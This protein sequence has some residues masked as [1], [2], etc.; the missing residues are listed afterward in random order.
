MRQYGIQALIIRP[1]WRVL[2]DLFSGFLSFWLV[3]GAGILIDHI[4]T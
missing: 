2:M 3:F 1:L 4:D